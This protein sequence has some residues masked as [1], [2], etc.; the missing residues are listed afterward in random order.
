MTFVIDFTDFT[1]E[2]LKPP[3][4]IDNTVSLILRWIR[5][6]LTRFNTPPEFNTWLLIVDIYC[7]V[8]VVG[9]NKLSSGGVLWRRPPPPKFVSYWAALNFVHHMFRIILREPSGPIHH[10]LG[11]LARDGAK[12]AI[13]DVCFN[14]W[15]TALRNGCIALSDAGKVAKCHLWQ[16]DK[17]FRWIRWR[18]RHWRCAPKRPQQGRFYHFLVA[19]HSMCRGRFGPYDGGESCKTCRR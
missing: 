5:V 15:Y 17:Q 16:N 9:L 1:T 3:G 11:F 12:S 8:G 6:G 2:T 13:W 7:C 4:H 19:G 18:D 10:Q 14:M